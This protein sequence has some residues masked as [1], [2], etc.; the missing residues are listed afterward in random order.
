MTIF[1]TDVDPR[2]R[3][4]GSRDGLGAQ[5]V[6]SAT[7]RPLIGN[8]TTVTESLPGFTTLLVGLRLA[9]FADADRSENPTDAFLIW[10]Q[11]AAYVRHAGGERGFF[12]RQRVAARAAKAGGKVYLSAQPEHQ[13]L[14]NQRTDGL[15]GNYTAPARASGLVAPGTPTRLT[16]EAAAFVDAVHLPRLEAGWGKDACRLVRELGRDRV[17]FDLGAAEKREAV[18]D[19]FRPVTSR[20]EVDFYRHHLVEGGPA[21]PT[22]GRQ[23]RFALLL[24]ARPTDSGLPSRPYLTAIADDAETRGWGDVADLVR[25]VIACESVLAPAS[26]LFR[27]LLS[28]NGARLDDV[29]A[30]LRVTCGERVDSVDPLATSVLPGPHWPRI[31]AALHGGDYPQLIRVLAERNGTVMRERGGALAWLEVT[32]QDQLRV[33]FRDEPADLPAGD[34][35]PELWWYPYFIPSLVSVLRAIGK[36]TA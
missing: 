10:E 20:R 16:P 2:A 7:G 4:K 11:M 8:L 27:Y 33:R 36:G 18:A 19:V 21:D 28:R 22:G 25:R 5:A 35:I 13:I 24:D 3:V 29:A 12:G 14:G 15:L 32:G 6:W 1:L 9:E 23:S 17:V 26:L 34:H 30:E 31:A